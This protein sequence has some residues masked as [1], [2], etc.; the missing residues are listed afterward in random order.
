MGEPYFGPE[1]NKFNLSTT[2]LTDFVYSPAEKKF[3]T[4]VWHSNRLAI[5]PY[6]YVQ[7]ISIW[8][9]YVERSPENP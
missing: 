6:K 8:N 9:V 1:I 4:P 3:V 2:V 5:T 7:Q